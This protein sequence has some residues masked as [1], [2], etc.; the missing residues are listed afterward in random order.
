[1]RARHDALRLAH[2]RLDLRR[3]GDAQEQNFGIAR[4]L[5]GTRC[6][7]GAAPDQIVDRSAVAMAHEG[8]H[9]PLLDQAFRHAVAHEADADETDA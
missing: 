6:L 9:M 4:N 5:G 8:Q 7:L 1:M 2:Q 3:A